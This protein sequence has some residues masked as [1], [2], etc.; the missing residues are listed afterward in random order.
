MRSDCDNESTEEALSVT[1]PLFEK[2]LPKLAPDGVLLL[3]QP[4]GK[5]DRPEILLHADKYGWKCDYALTWLKGTIKAGNSIYPYRVCTEK[6]LVFSRK[7]DKVQKQESALAYSDILD[8]Q[9]GTQSATIKM[10]YGK[11]KMGDYH[12]F[13]KPIELMEFLIKQHSFASDLIVEPFGCSGS[14]LISA[15]RL[16]RNWLY[17]ESNQDNYNWA[18][19]RIKETVAELSTQAG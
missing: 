1:L 12:I 18:S 9:T 8:F 15:A 13:Q 16:N 11:I 3:F 6:I 7:Q 17:I 14:G 5:P 19:Q 10:D 2:C 4:G